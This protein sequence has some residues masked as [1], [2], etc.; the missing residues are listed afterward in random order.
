[1]YFKR[2]DR[3]VTVSSF[4]ANYSDVVCAGDNTMLFSVW[5]ID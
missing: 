4:T 1:M 5:I 3:F 2:Y